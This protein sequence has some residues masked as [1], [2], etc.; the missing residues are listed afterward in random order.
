L[1][2]EL[3]THVFLNQFRR[4]SDTKPGL[5]AAVARSLIWAAA[6]KF[7]SLDYLI[8][9]A[10]PD[11]MAVFPDAVASICAASQVIPDPLI[12]IV[13]AIASHFGPQIFTAVHDNRAVIIIL[14]KFLGDRPDQAAAAAQFVLG[15]PS[16][17]TEIALV[18]HDLPCL[19][20]AMRRFVSLIFREN[21]GLAPV[22]IASLELTDECARLCLAYM[23]QYLPEHFDVFCQLA[24]SG[25]L[26]F[27]TAAVYASKELELWSD[28]CGKVRNRS[29]NLDALLSVIDDYAK[30]GNTGKAVQ[31]L[32]CICVKYAGESHE[33]FD[34]MGM[35]AFE[36]FQNLHAQHC[37]DIL[38]CVKIM[39]FVHPYA[40]MIRPIIG[41]D[42]DSFEP[43][44]ADLA[45]RCLW[46]ARTDESPD[47]LVFRLR[48]L[49]HRRRTGQTPSFWTDDMLQLK[50]R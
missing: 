29:M 15:R 3:E 25:V 16:L 13:A 32:H 5:F 50:D 49:I 18:M 19:N 23:R 9:R 24:H 45:F 4:D 31:L 7:D 20:C 40:D 47:F 21:P 34:R 11:F 46:V 48:L 2:D 38:M 44:V 6:T 36:V 33:L 17:W 12:P 41:A 22:L 27:R 28:F 1:A 37:G 8:A 10:T 39:C 14:K 42:I 35:F 30:S 43:R 26:S